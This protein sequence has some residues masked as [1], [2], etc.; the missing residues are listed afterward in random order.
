MNI[1]KLFPDK[2]TSRKGILEFFDKKGFY[3]VLVLCI[4]II[5]V[6]G[7]FVSTYDIASSDEDYDAQKII[8][9][10][11]NN[12]ASNNEGKVAL[13]P[14][15]DTSSG[16]A[17]AKEQDN[18]A[19][20]TPKPQANE[21]KQTMP[22]KED[23]S[24]NKNGTGKANTSTDNKKVSPAKV[25]KF[26]MP[27]FGNVILEYAQDKLVFSKTLDEWRT[28]S[29]LDLASDR[30]T[31]VKVVAD[32]V[33]YEVKNDPRLGITIVVDHQNGIKT[34]YANLASDNMVTP[35]QKLKQGDVIGS[36]GNT[37]NFEAADQAHLHFEVLKNDEPVDPSTYLNKK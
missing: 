20:A 6:V 37:A 23:K 35:N 2:K 36:V 18:K 24:T 14:S 29:G 11:F 32:G 15:V 34:V 3:V 10:E 33:V 4:A 13:Q 17:S 9:E 31:P 8:P 12:K 5:G 16:V 30:G 22:P 25:Q 7:Y 26:A 28:H 27:V 1:K 19:I 21:N